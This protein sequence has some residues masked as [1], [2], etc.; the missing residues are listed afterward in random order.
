MMYYEVLLI[1]ATIGLM[2]MFREK[3]QIVTIYQGDESTLSEANEYYWI[4]KDNNIPFKYHIPYNWENFFQFGYKKC[5]V[6][7]KV[8]KSDVIRARRIMWC[9]RKEKMEMERNIRGE[10]MR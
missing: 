3:Q 9:Y 8:K 5:S 7:I 6:Y 10:R 1:I 2:W 4:L